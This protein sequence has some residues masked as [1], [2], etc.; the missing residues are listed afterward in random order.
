MSS[1]N[2]SA[3][4]F[5]E[6]NHLETQ[7]K[8]DEAIVQEVEGPIKHTYIHLDDF[9]FVVVDILNAIV[10][11]KV[12]Y[13]DKDFDTDFWDVDWFIIYKDPYFLEFDQR[14]S[15][16]G[17][18]KV[19]HV[20]KILLLMCFSRWWIKESEFIFKGSEE[21]SQQFGIHKLIEK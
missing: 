8:Q 11:D 17:Q 13:K 2:D 12:F 21:Q 4:A 6:D 16:D 19:S 5:P 20:F 10:Q 18:N 1:P 9:S 7:P 15:I 14:C 3:E